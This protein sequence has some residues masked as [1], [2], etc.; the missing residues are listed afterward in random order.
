MPVGTQGDCYDRY[1]IRCEEMRQVCACLCCRLTANSS[2]CRSHATLSALQSLRIIEQCLNDMPEGEVRVYR[3][4][5]VDFAAKDDGSADDE[6]AVVRQ[7]LSP[8]ITAE[9]RIID[10]QRIRVARVRR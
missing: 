3:G 6:V 8:A 4:T 7:V 5:A 2:C 10:R 9:R 1:C